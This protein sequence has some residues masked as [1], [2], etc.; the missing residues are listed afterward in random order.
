MIWLIFFVVTILGY[1]SFIFIRKIKMHRSRCEHIRASL[2]LPTENQKNDYSSFFP[3]GL[4]IGE[5]LWQVYSIDPSVIKAVDFSSQEE[6][7]SALD[8]SNY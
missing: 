2:H 7:K 1:S 8:V 4:A 6:L 3:A 5:Y